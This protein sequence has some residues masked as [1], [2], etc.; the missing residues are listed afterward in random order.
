[1]SLRLKFGILLG[2]LGLAVLLVASA[3]WLTFD[4]LR[5]QVRDPILSMTQVL[6]QLGSIKRDV[7]SLQGV[8]SSAGSGSTVRQPSTDE[9]SE[10]ARASKSALDIIASV[11]GAQESSEEWALRT[12]KTSL[13]NIQGRLSQ[14]RAQSE[15]FFRLIADPGAPRDRQVAL[16]DECTASLADIQHLLESMETRLIADTKLAIGASDVLRQ[17]LIVV[18]GSAFVIVALASTLGVIL[19]RRWVL[20]PV[21]QLRLATARIAEGEFTYRIPTPSSPPGNDELL[22]LSAEVNHMAGMIKTMQDDRVEREKLAALGEMIRRLAHNLRNPLSGI[23]GLAENSRTELAALGMPG[24][25][26]T[27]LQTRIITSVDRFE[28]WLN[29]LLA[30]T[31]PMEIRPEPT[32]VAQWLTGLVD[33]HRPLAQTRG[34]ELSLD[35]AHSPAQAVFDDRHLEH[36][37]SAILSNAIEATSSPQ[38]RGDA[39]TGG[40]VEVRVAG[41]NGHS[42]GAWSIAVADEGPG[43]PP[44]LREQIFRPYFTTKRDGNGIGLAVALQVVKAHGGRITVESPWKPPET[45]SNASHGTRFTIELPANRPVVANEV[46]DGPASNGRD[47]ASSGQNPRHR[48]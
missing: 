34:V 33:A 47:G 21:G 17:K 25:E 35:A 37:V 10:F 4:T 23:R 3:S 28:K 1:M 19:V 42:G 26:L 15:E 45:G 30:A 12:S 13:R 43:V 31:R 2:L 40:R 29:D 32:P 39:R 16:R 7:E 41:E 8:V 20:D 38:A 48:R 27:E 22:T 36:A 5:H 46:Q 11:A 44:D 24:V 14:T 6:Q 18:L 9:L